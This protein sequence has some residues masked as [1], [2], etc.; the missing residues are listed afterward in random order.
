MDILV[1][2]DHMYEVPG[3]LGGVEG[4]DGTSQYSLLIKWCVVPCWSLKRWS[5]TGDHPQ[6]GEKMAKVLSCRTAMFTPPA[7]ATGTEFPRRYPVC[8]NCKECHFRF[9]SLVVQGEDRVRDHLEQAAARRRQK[10]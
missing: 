9:A 3:A 6:P 5:A 4:G 7:Q 8:K 1:G 10:K 2:M